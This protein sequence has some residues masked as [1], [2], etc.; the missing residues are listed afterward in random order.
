MTEVEKMEDW[1]LP[2]ELVWENIDKELRPPKKR[3]SLTVLLPWMSI[4]ASSL[5]LL[6]CF[7]MYQIQQITPLLTQHIEWK[8]VKSNLSTSVKLLAHQFVTNKEE[9][10]EW[11]TV[12][13][14][15]ITLVS[16]A[17][18]AEKQPTITPV[19]II[20]KLPTLD[21]ALPLNENKVLPKK[22]IDGAINQSLLLTQT[23]DQK[24]PKTNHNP[25]IRKDAKRKPAIY[26][27]AN[28]TPFIK[29]TIVAEERM[30]AVDNIANTQ[31]QKQSI[32]VGLSLIHI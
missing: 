8:E 15:S 10:K 19:D 18:A 4:A 11:V 27:A 31:Q 22:M 20:K 28:V 32:G 2:A 1:K 25:L 24:P 9:E 7:Q 3:N 5:L 17:P 30:D 26:V 21:T 29:E 23:V 14:Q 13:E 6:G 12:K 16:L